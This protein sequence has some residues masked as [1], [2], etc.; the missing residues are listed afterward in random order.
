MQF[1]QTLFVI[2]LVV[3]LV[4]I[5]VRKKRDRRTRSGF[6]KGNAPLHRLGLAMSNIGLVL[7]IVSGLILA[8]HYIL[9]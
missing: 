3:F 5:T 8:I 6:V 4:G 1:V 2:G 9:H 7:L